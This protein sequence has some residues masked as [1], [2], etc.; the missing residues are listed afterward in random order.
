L[1][2]EWY[3]QTKGTESQLGLTIIIIIFITITTFL[4]V[5]Y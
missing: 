2:S 3:N 5:L 4:V 1:F